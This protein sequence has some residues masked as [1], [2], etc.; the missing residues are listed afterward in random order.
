MDKTMS[1]DFTIEKLD[2]VLD[3]KCINILPVECNDDSFNRNRRFEALGLEHSIKWYTNVSYLET[4]GVSVVF[5]TVRQSNTWPNNAKMN[6]QFEN[7]NG[8]TVAVLPIEMH[9]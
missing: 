8:V 1:N 2:S 5:Y 9:P 4:N 7:E 3:H 6:L